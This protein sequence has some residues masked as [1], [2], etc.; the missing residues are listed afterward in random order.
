MNDNQIIVKVFNQVGSELQDPD[1]IAW[2][3]IDSGNKKK[4]PPGGDPA[5]FAFEVVDPLKEVKVTVDPVKKSGKQALLKIIL[6]SATDFDTT[7][8]FTQKEKEN[9][10][11]VGFG[12]MAPNPD[13][14]SVIAPPV[15][16]V[17]VGEDEDPDPVPSPKPGT[18]KT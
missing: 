8:K 3:N 10:W 15:V 6:S 4:V 16:N 2:K 7:V 9:K 12:G 18:A 11:V 17:T 13:D 5:E 14:G 1:I